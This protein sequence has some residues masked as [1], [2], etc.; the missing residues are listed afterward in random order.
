MKITYR[1][2]II[3]PNSFIIDDIVEMTTDRYND[4][5]EEFEARLSW[6]MSGKQQLSSPEFR[7]LVRPQIKA[8]IES[9]WEDYTGQDED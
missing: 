3:H 4:N 9:D 6:L 8:V 7:A 1:Y 5:R 2:Q